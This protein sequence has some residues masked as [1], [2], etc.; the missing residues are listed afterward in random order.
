MEIINMEALEK[1]TGGGVVSVC[2]DDPFSSDE[3]EKQESKTAAFNSQ[4]PGNLFKNP[5]PATRSK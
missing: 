1:V 3:E 2:I 5:G 4:N